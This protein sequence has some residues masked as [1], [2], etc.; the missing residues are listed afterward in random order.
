MK[1]ILSISLLF[2][3]I[4]LAGCEKNR[5]VCTYKN[6]EVKDAE[7]KT[8]YVFTFDEDTIKKVTMETEIVL[9]GD[10]NNESFI[11]GYTKIATSLASSYEKI[12]GVKAV[13]NSD[14]NIVTLR[15][16][17]DPSKMGDEDIET[18]GLNLTKELLKQEL[19]GEGYT[20]K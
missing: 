12:D 5:L 17:M 10:Y 6:T 11:S 9:S 13:V 18:Y 8:K 3:I 7:S 16:E 19:E 2:V 20:C 1:K 4:F 14:K 15:V